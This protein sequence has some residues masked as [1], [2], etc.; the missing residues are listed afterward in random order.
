M[1]LVQWGQ[2]ST[3]S[4]WH[5]EQTTPQTNANSL[6]SLPVDFRVLLALNRKEV[7]T[8]FTQE[9][10]VT[11]AHLDEYFYNDQQDSGSPI[12]GSFIITPK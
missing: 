4:S 3:A 2:F 1:S 5:S 8:V 9:S 7:W 12:P 11:G 10:M 6:D